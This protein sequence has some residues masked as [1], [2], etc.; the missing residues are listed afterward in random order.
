MGG[1]QYKVDIQQAVIVTW[2]QSV[3]IS[4][5]KAWS[6]FSWDNHAGQRTVVGLQACMIVSWQGTTLKVVQRQNIAIQL[7]GVDCSDVP[8]TADAPTVPVLISSSDSFV[9]VPMF[10]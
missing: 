1:N 8:A 5:A 9:E 2:W 10:T 3:S 6:N 7:Y 4:L